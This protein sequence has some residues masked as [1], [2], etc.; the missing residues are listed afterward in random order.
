MRIRYWA[1]MRKENV[2][3]R[4]LLLLLY[5]N[6]DDYWFICPL[7]NNYNIILLYRYDQFIHKCIIIFA[8]RKIHILLLHIASWSAYKIHTIPHY[9]I[10]PVLYHSKSS[11]Q[12]SILSYLCPLIHIRIH[13]HTH[14]D[15]SSRRFHSF[16][17]S[18]I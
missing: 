2:N 18:L 14:T 10:M 6:N 16:S 13:I 8:K 9:V 15:H 11:I 12:F 5:N 17:S 4:L 3:T 1:L 7:S